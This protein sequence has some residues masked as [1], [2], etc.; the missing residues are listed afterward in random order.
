MCNYQLYRCCLRSAGSVGTSRSFC[1]AGGL[2]PPCSAE[3]QAGGDGGLGG[4]TD[5]MEHPRKQRHVP[6]RSA[7]RSVLRAAAGRLRQHIHGRQRLHVRPTLPPS[8]GRSLPRKKRARKLQRRAAGGAD[9]AGDITRDNADGER[10]RVAQHH[11]RC[12]RCK[13]LVLSV[14]A[15]CG[16][17]KQMLRRPWQS[18]QWVGVVLCCIGAGGSTDMV[19]IV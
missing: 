16:G 18:T 12:S 11:G 17:C 19:M 15:L 5:P 1:C 3:R 4:A 8:H 10:A 2:G 7:D 14:C 6:A 13:S 9:F